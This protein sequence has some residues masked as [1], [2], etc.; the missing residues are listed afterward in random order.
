MRTRLGAQR[1]NN[2][3]D[4]IWEGARRLERERLARG[5]KPNPN[6]T[7]FKEFDTS[8]TA[9]IEEAERYQQKLYDKYDNVSVTPIGLNRVR[10]I[11]RSKG[12]AWC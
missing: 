11:G 10:I 3:M 8:T 6:L 9:G 1:Y 7:D 5:E 12:G 4:K 2:R